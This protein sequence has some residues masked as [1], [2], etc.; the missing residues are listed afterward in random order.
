MFELDVVCLQLT[1]DTSCIADND[2]AWLKNLK[3]PSLGGNN[4]IVLDKIDFQMNS[5]RFYKIEKL[6]F[7][8]E[9]PMR[10]AF[11]NVLL[12]IDS[13]GVDLVY[14]IDGDKQGIS[15]Y[16]GVIK[17]NNDGTNLNA[18]K[19]GSIVSRAFA[20]NYN[21]S[22]LST[23]TND[24]DKLRNTVFDL[25]GKHLEYA[26]RIIGVPGINENDTADNVD[27]QGMDR[28]I[29]TMLGSN[30]RFVVSCEAVTRA[31]VSELQNMVYDLY[32]KLAPFS[33]ASFQDG[34]SKNI[35]V[36]NGTNYSDTSGWN[37]G[38]SESGSSNRG[39][40]SSGGT[41]TWGC[42]EEKG[43]Q[44]G[45]SGS[46]T[47]GRNSSANF[48]YAQ[49][50]SQTRE[51]VNKQAAE[52]MKYIDEELLPR[53]NTGYARGLYRTSIT[54]MAENP[55]EAS[56]LKSAILSLFRGSG[57]SFNSLTS[58][59]L[60][61]DGTTNGLDDIYEQAAGSVDAYL[62]NCRPVLQNGNVLLSTYLTPKEVSIFAALPQKEVPGLA[63]R[64]SVEFGLNPKERECGRPI[65]L[66]K[67]VRSGRVLDIPFMLDSELLNKHTFI[68]GVT[69]SGKTTT[70]HSI[71]KSAG[72]PF[73][74]IE[75]AKTEYRALINSADFKNITV[76]TL[77]N[78]KAAPFRFNPFELVEGELLSAHIDMLK[79]AFTSAFPMEASMPQLLEEAIVRCYEKKG[80]N[81]GLNENIHSA[82]RISDDEKGD[83]FPI[84]SELLPQ[85]EEVV[86]EK[87]FG[88]EL[89]ANYVGS[90]VSRLSNLTVGAKGRMLN[91]RH[92]VDFDHILRR[93]VII[94]MDEIRSSEDKSLIM[95]FYL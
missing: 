22:E 67:I 62:L 26:G 46:H 83:V 66:G 43:T 6:S 15:V 18:A 61:A 5:Y 72:V 10:E 16:L 80:W 2:T 60:P 47:T 70:C 85:L 1:L 17:K 51:I 59:A 87:K 71:L 33:R 8:E 91:C 39:G 69:G 38:T 11:E 49:S 79:A 54:Y 20:S 63:L 34:S 41:S 14:I 84:L 44:K 35:G 74:V 88:A 23:V 21:G 53:L 9:Y 57:S 65:E 31:E 89:Q 36:S 73:M 19:L 30:W 56:R 68:A 42:S 50:A 90:L 78:E 64:E 76:F 93:N 37:F 75:P 28:L 81:V 52:V 13:P 24:N 86:K 55:V 82:N 77:G 7:D 48:S 95:G 12:T 45:K 58:I 4:R 94:E 32:N 29:N 25:S 3:F 27:F 40:G 92:S